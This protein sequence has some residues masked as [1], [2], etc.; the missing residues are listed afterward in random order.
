MSCT[1]YFVHT[2][3]LMEG[4][5]FG[6]EARTTVHRVDT[7]RLTG[8]TRHDSQLYTLSAALVNQEV[9][10]APITASEPGSLLRLTTDQPLDV[11]LNASNASMLSAVLQLILGASISALFL[12]VPGQTP[13]TVRVEVFGGGSIQASIP[14]P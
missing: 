13:A 10:L 3:R 8:V 11:R 9:N 5:A 14:A 1:G 12:G 7:L 6:A 4:D 2:L